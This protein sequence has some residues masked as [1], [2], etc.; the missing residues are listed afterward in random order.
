MESESKNSQRA[1]ID[2]LIKARLSRQAVKKGIPSHDRSQTTSL[3]YGQERLWFLEQFS[4]DSQAY[5]R[6][7]HLRIKGPL[8]Q[9]ALEKTLEALTQRHESLRTCFIT[10]DDGP[11]QTIQKQIA[12]PVSLENLQDLPETERE[13]YAQKRVEQE[14]MAKLSWR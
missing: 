8:D 1:L 10:G 2:R 12:I 7:A 3:S 9:L 13:E 14:T 4:P 5:N 6:P 11:E